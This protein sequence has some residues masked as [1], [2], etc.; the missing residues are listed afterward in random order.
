M[1]FYLSILSS[2]QLIGKGVNHMVIPGLSRLIMVQWKSVTKIWTLSY[3]YLKG[4]LLNVG[5]VGGTLEDYEDSA[6]D[7][8][9]LQHHWQNESWYVMHFKFLHFKPWIKYNFKEKDYKHGS[10]LIEKAVFGSN[11]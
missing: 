11:K 4:I 8:A 1:S 2:G 10:N 9:G 6:P 7:S 3:I 5:F